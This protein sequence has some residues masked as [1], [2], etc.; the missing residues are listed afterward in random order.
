[1]I[2]EFKNIKGTLL[3]LYFAYFGVEIHIPGKY[4][5]FIENL[6]KWYK[7]QKRLVNLQ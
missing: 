1:M 6:T 7:K 3:I 4:N 2:M 5:V